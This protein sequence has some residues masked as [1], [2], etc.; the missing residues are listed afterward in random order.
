VLS[1]HFS[2]LAELVLSWQF[3]ILAELVP[4]HLTGHPAG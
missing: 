3:N 2:L 4:E 1:W